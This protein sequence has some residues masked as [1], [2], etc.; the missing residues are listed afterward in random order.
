MGIRGKMFC[1]LSPKGMRVKL[2]GLGEET[3]KRMSGCG[4]NVGIN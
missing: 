1:T 3:P 2:R 4:E